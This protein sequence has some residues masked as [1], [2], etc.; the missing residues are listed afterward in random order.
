MWCQHRKYCLIGSANEPKQLAFGWNWPS[1]SQFNDWLQGGLF[2]IKWTIVKACHIHRDCLFTLH[3]QM[4]DFTHAFNTQFKHALEFFI[5]ACCFSKYTFQF[6]SSK[7]PVRMYTIFRKKGAEKEPFNHQHHWKQCFILQLLDWKNLIYCERI[8]F[9]RVH[10]ESFT[11]TKS[12]RGRGPVKLLLLD[13]VHCMGD[14]E[15]GGLLRCLNT[16]GWIG[17]LDRQ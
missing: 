16:K 1:R 5:L 10:N 3:D 7:F 12:R 17:C 11:G 2:F 8:R 6:Y 9:F 14:I 15:D 13:T 4:F